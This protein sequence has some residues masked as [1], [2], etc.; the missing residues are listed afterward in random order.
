[1]SAVNAVFCQLMTS[2]KG[3]VGGGY[4]SPG[5]F[6]LTVNVVPLSFLKKVSFL[7]ISQD[8]N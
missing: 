4:V 7:G 6:G 5:I 8:L 3:L 1:M 2:C